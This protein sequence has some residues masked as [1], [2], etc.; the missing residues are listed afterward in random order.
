MTKLVTIHHD[1][2]KIQVRVV[3]TEFTY[4]HIMIVE[5]R[6]E[7][8]TV[9]RRDMKLVERCEDLKPLDNLILGIPRVMNRPKRGFVIPVEEF[10]QYTTKELAYRYN[11][12]ETTIYN[13]KHALMKRREELV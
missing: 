1:G 2:K 13:K 7:R 11:C 8:R 9:R 4:D 5:Y 6:G 10:E 3:P 12:D